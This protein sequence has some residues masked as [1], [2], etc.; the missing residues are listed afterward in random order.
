MKQAFIFLF[1]LITAAAQSQQKVIQLYNGAA[2]GSE[3]WNWPEGE[4]D[5]NMFRTKL[6]YNVTKPTLTVYAPDPSIANGTAI[7]IAPGGGFHVLSINSEGIDVAKWLVQRGVTCFVLKY[8]LVHVISNDPAGEMM[9]AINRRDSSNP[10]GPVIT[11]AIADGRV[12]IEYVRKHAAEYNVSTDRIG[13]IGFSAGGT[14]AGSSAFNYTS[15][16]KPDFVAPIY[17]YLPPQMIG[18]VA[19]DAPPMFI[20]AASDD[21][22]SLA[23]HSAEL[24]KKWLES[25][26]PVE[27]HMY[28]KGGH[29]FG[30]RTQNLP[31]D[32][33]IERFGEWLDVMGLLKKK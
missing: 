15:A 7:I 29:G 30:M 13:I 20:A 17:A 27:L 33:W 4:S 31:S 12:A 26:H 8:R 25:K 23:P 1:L 2:P 5:N 21:Q 18:T 3:T 6:V 9:A 28:A 11:M 19:A 10:M 24:Y 32:K 16:N 14:V 22:L